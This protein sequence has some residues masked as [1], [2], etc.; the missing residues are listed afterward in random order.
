MGPA[1]LTQIISIARVPA[2]GP[3]PVF[4]DFRVMKRICY[5]I[6]DASRARLVRQ[7][8][9]D[10]AFVTFEF[11]AP[12]PAIGVGRRALRTGHTVNFASHGVRRHQVQPKMGLQYRA[13]R[14]FAVQIL[15]RVDSLLS[16]GAYEA[17]VL[18]AP[19]RMLQAFQRYMNANMR[20]RLAGQLGKDLSKTPDH[21]LQGHLWTVNLSDLSRGAGRQYHGSALL[22]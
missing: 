4:E 13:I 6:A 7:R 8:I 19:P 12:D 22:H 18:V 15:E 11:L 17:I 16:M 3:N 5:V 21:D 14:A 9:E 10:G 2:L 20:T 1:M